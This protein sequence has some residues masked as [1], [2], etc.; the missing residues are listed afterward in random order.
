[1]RITDRE[2]LK[3]VVEREVANAKI[4]DVH[5]HIYP[6]SFDKL[7][8]W[9]ID[10]LLTYHYLIAEY[11]RYSKMGY[12]EFFGLSKREQADI[13]WKILFIEHSPVS[14]AQRGVLTVLSR[15]GLDV[16]SR[17]LD[18]YRK[19]F[20]SMS[21]SE[22]IDK[23]FELSGVS[24]VVMTNDPFDQM[25]K[26]MWEF[27][28]NKDSRFNAALRIDP[29][30]NSFEEAHKKLIE[31]GYK[32]DKVLDTLTIEEIKRFL[33]DWI[34]KMD[35]LYMAVS[36]PPDFTV[37]EDSYRSRII[38][39][40]IIPICREFDI[41]FAMMIGVNKLV[42]YKLGLAGD[43]VGKGSIKTLEYLCK[44]Y[45]NNKFMVTMLAREN[46]HELAITAR[47]FRNLFIFGCWWFLNN[48]S[49]VEEMTRIRMET[50]GLSFMPQHSDARVLDQ[51]IYKWSHSKK[52]IAKVLF[53]KY[54]DI[55]DSGWTA[56]EEE[57]RR[58]VKDI[59]GS[60]FWNFIGKEK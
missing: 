49:I 54:A 19:Y 16:S 37:P 60:N 29:L 47:K 27:E 1:M 52:I 55:L 31:W 43:S 28:G 3:N 12:E 48:P 7:L 22:Y 46:Q 13:I 15:L 11:F 14:E 17:D 59:F 21:A 34:K 53:D 9:G 57:I 36:L 20:D 24:E 44:T 6:E 18:S 45:P 10:E 38:E 39:S 42:N 25:E 4:T 41:P 58:D 40:C 56:E 30:L 26:P 8:L 32:V 51:L 5:T 35:A 2:M 33:R 50:L 23:V